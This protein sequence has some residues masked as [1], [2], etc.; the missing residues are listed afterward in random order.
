MWGFS[1][2]LDLLAETEFLSTAEATATTPIN[3]LILSACDIRHVIKTLSHRRRHPN[4]TQARPL[5]FYMLDS[6]NEVIARHLL[7]LSVITD[8]EVSDP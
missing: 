3:I 5:H 7:L 8:W 1:P 6:P 2:A 4:A